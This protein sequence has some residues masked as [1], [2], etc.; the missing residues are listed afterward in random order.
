MSI[1]LIPPVMYV[2]CD[3]GSADTNINFLYWWPHL[4]S[5]LIS[6]LL[7]GIVHSYLNKVKTN[8][9][10]IPITNCFE[11]P[12]M[13]MNSYVIQLLYLKDIEYLII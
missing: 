3:G 11:W 5:K 1:N 4:H 2:Y 8:Y 13:S 9:S 12:P 7:Q 10:E 6:K